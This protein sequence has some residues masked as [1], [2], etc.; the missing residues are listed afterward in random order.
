MVPSDIDQ[1]EATHSRER[2][3]VV[4]ALLHRHLL[5]RRCVG[6]VHIGNGP[7]GGGRHHKANNAHD[8]VSPRPRGILREQRRKGRPEDVSARRAGPVEAEDHVLSHSVGVHRPQQCQPVG[9]QKGRAHALEAAG[10]GEEDVVGIVACSAKHGPYSVPCEGGHEDTLVPV[11]VAQTSGDEDESAGSQA[12]GGD[13]PAQLARI[14]DAEVVSNNV[15]RGQSLT[16]T[17][18][19]Q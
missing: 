14:L 9:R 11:H 17:S 15:K 10:D 12:E 7:D 13:V 2:A 19:G 5:L 6:A 8:P 4:E 16:D 3:E 18:L 1:H